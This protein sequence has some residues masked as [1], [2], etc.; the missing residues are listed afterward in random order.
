MII[1][2]P[3]DTEIWS[4]FRD[5]DNEALSLIYTE[6]SK[7]LYLYGLKFTKNQAIIEDSMQ[8]LFTDLIA[9]RRKLGFTDSVQ[10]YLI[11]S[12]KRRLLRQLQMEKRYNLKDND[13]EYV[14]DISY[15]VEH[16]IIL[17]EK[18]NQKLFLLHKALMDL[19]PR[20]KEAV[21]LKYTEN[22]EY[23]EIAEIMEMSIEGCRNLIYRA[24]KSLKDSINHFQKNGRANRL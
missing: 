21:Y 24:I 9:N 6:N 8:N 5:G 1:L 11:K 16:D 17:E 23:E 2:K 22:L 15:S 13:E 20:Q 12:F 10:F 7:R 4:K 19:T 3:S 14:F 18:S